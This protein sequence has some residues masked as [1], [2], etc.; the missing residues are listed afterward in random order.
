M[1]LNKNWKM[2]YKGEVLNCKKFPVSM[3]QTLYMNGRA[4]DP[5]YGE[6]QE[7]AKELSREDCE[8]YCDFVPEGEM[9]SCDKIFI[10][11]YGLDTLAQVYLNGDLLF[12]SSNMFATFKHDITQNLL[13]GENRLTVKFSSPL[14]YAENAYNS[15]KLYG[16]EGT[17][18]GYQHIRK[19]HYSFGW[20]WGPQLPDMGIWRDVEIE[21]V[22]VCQIENVYFKQD[23]NDDF[24]KLTLTVIPQLN[25]L[26]VKPLE[27]LTEI[28][29]SDGRSLISRKSLTKSEKTRFTI[30]NPPLWN[31]RCGSG[32]K[33]QPLQQVTLTV[34]ENEK[35]ICRH[36]ERIGFRKLTVNN[37]PVNGKFCFVCNG[38]EI[39]AMGAN[40]IPSDQIL[41][42]V[43]DKRI[44]EMLENC[45][46]MGF[47]CVRVWGGGIYPDN[48]FLD[49]CDE[50]GLILWQDFMFAC[51]AYKLNT[52]FADSV[53]KEVKDNVI[54]LRN[55]PCL[56]LWCGNNEIESMWE[57]WN[58]PE[59]AEAKEDYVKL[60]EEII[61]NQLKQLD[62]Q[63]F[64]W[65]SSPSSGGNQFNS[66]EC[67]KESANCD[68][69]DQHFWAVW[70]GFAPLEEFRKNYFP[71]CSEYGFESIPSVKTIAAFSRKQDMNL[72]SPVMEAHQ[73]CTLGNEKLL[74]YIAQMCRC[75]KSFEETV[76]AT[77]LVQA[78]SIRLN[79]EHL[80]RNRGK[81]MGSLFWQL[82]DSNPVISWS[83][84][85]Y[86]GRPKALYYASKRFYAPIL[87]SC[88][89]ENIKDIQLHITND[90]FQAAEGTV[91]WLLRRN[92]GVILKSGQLGFNVP[93]LSASEII[94][95]DFSKE[96]KETEDRRSCFLE[97]SAVVG[98]KTVSRGSTIFVRPKSFKFL[99]PQ[100]SLSLEE[101]PSQFILHL[102][103]K[104][105]AKG[106]WLDLK[107]GD[108]IFSDNF[109]DF[110]G[111][112]DV[113]VEKDS[114]TKPYNAQMFKS[115]LSAVCCY[116][117]QY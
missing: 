6:N 25:L 88:L 35:V 76:Y 113:I 12:N 32:D 64:Y 109:F 98:G 43:G 99:N 117:L 14:V 94:A 73:K 116:D 75:P 62:P 100:L 2:V 15:R 97:Y 54:R 37:D 28:T 114:V 21:G 50:L 102:K 92:D 82:N 81:C 29:L 95:L 66:S 77:Q 83:A 68:K 22:S 55:H 90:T 34:L 46:E 10:T 107:E 71:F 16:V 26:G 27:L 85:D 84:V 11:F 41:P 60:F 31:V 74:F 24:S 105:F 115:K 111:K 87:L 30:E 96:L 93:A 103:S 63:T 67:F 89:E 3:Y 47:N 91:S 18:P 48:H 51:A 53:K 65:P 38:R 45:V 61:P 36:T 57:G 33:N 9:F 17:V 39:F 69:G 108:C 1:L 44:D 13:K 104:A 79:A 80:R 70:H 56:G 40:I 8:F 20:D 23:F 58:V 78:E 72:T 5:Y 101:T 52:A 59:D 7:E 112:Y 86:Y 4:D 106:V 19:A 110:C 42:F 49:R